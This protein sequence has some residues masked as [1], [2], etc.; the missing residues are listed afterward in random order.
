MKKRF[1]AGLLVLSMLVA[2]CS[3]TAS[4]TATKAPVEVYVDGQHVGRTP[5]AQIELSNGVW[6]EPYCYF[7]EDDGR[8]GTCSIQKE[9]K[10]APL[11]IGLFI[12]PVLLWCYGPKSSQVVFN[13]PEPKDKELEKAAA[14]APAQPAAAPAQP[15]AAPAQ[16]AAAPVQP[17]QGYLDANGQI[18]YLDSKGEHY[19]LDPNGRPYYVDKNGRPYYK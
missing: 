19:Y 3:T 7:I 9:I 11:I 13:L 8:R 5:N 14:Q 10:V 1:V 16:P 18:Y 2:S 4:F 12:L 6:N 17:P 15:A